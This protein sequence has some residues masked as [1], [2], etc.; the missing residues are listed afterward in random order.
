M[1]QNCK[2]LKNAKYHVFKFRLEKE[3]LKE[4][5]ESENKYFQV[6]RFYTLHTSSLDLS[7]VEEQVANCFAFFEKATIA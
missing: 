1:K 4:Y 7:L 6:C 2:D 3:T 5:K